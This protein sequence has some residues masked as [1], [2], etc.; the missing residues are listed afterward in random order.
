MRSTWTALISIALVCGCSV[1][2]LSPTSLKVSPTER[3]AEIR[4]FQS[5]RSI[6]DVDRKLDEL[7]AATDAQAQA[8]RLIEGWGKH[9]SWSDLAV[10]K[11]WLERSP[12][13]REEKDGKKRFDHHRLFDAAQKA[14][15]SHPTIAS[16]VYWYH[17]WSN[18]VPDLAVLMHN[19]ENFSG[20]CLS[21]SWTDYRMIL[22]CAG[23]ASGLPFECEAGGSAR[24]ANF[25]KLRQDWWEQK[26]L[27]L[28]QRP[29]LRYDDE[30]GRWVV[31]QEAKK[32]NRYLTPDEQRASE[33]PTP[34]PDWDSEIVPPRPV[35]V[36]L[37]N[38]QEEELL[39]IPTE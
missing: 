29:F 39:G 36:E 4:H 35:R 37:E 10:V 28:S 6:A 26:L 14:L 38:E 18:G 21:D 3:V 33:R 34:L 22:I 13:W 9:G 16:Q 20:G 5:S 31:D 32:A 2:D 8:E 1:I 27:I 12:G 30:L 25:D 24:R 11:L 15:A 7:L 23:I 17:Q 19:F